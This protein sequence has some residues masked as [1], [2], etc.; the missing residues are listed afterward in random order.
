MESYFFVIP[1]EN[2]HFGWKS[3]P[4]SLQDLARDTGN[5]TASV[6]AAALDKAVGTFL[7]LGRK[8]RKRSLLDH[9]RAT[10][11]LGESTG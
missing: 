10:R 8:R 11:K 5:E 7:K 9:P 4:E 3:H 1:M 2:P 6:L